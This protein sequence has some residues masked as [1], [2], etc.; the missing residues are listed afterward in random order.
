[1]LYDFG[2]L[3]TRDYTV[4]INEDLLYIPSH[5]CKSAMLQQGHL[6]TRRKLLGEAFLL[7]NKVWTETKR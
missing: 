7:G 6:M 3:S 5:A 2:E 1:M 4:E